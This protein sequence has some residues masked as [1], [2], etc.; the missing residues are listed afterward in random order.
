MGLLS[1]KTPEEVADKQ[2][3]KEQRRQELAQKFFMSSPAGQARSAYDRGDLVFQYDQDVINQ[4]AIIAAMM[5]STT[6]KR[7]HD[8]VTILN[9][10]CHEGWELV[11]GSFV[12]VEEGQESRD[13]FMSSGQN[14]AIKGRVV[15][16]YLFKRSE[17]N[18]NLA[19]R[20]E[21]EQD[22]FTDA[23]QAVEAE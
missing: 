15:G 8:S 4:K 18:L 12:F 6:T 16:Y 23:A 3:K 14:V 17:A 20:V 10:V 2:A 19:R 21:A 5:G 7:V 9:S 1:K 22:A 13:K 11:N